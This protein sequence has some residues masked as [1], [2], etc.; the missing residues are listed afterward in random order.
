GKKEFFNFGDFGNNCERL[1]CYYRQPHD[2][3]LDHDEPKPGKGMPAFKT[4]PKCQSFV[5]TSSTVCKYCGFVFPKSREE[6]I[7]ELV[8]ISYAD[9]MKKLETPEDFEI[10][11][12]ASGKSKN[13]VFR[14]IF[15]RWGKVGLIA[16]GKK[17]GWAD[18][19][20]YMLM[21]RYQAQNIRK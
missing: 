9:A 15:I 5:T 4:C 16:Y 21:R 2:Y 18:S 19:Y 3:S 17:H 11:A 20:P 13:W 1:G 10:Y 6:K 14:M 12:K 8:E 7:V